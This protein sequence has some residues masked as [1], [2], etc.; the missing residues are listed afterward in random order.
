MPVAISLS[1]PA[2]VKHGCVRRTKS[3][4]QLFHHAIEMLFRFRLQCLRG[5]VKKIWLLLFH[6]FTSN[7]LNCQRRYR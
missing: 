7:G 1:N 6:A 4:I 3:L 5:T 2:K